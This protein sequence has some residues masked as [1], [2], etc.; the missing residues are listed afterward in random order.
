MMNW[1]FVKSFLQYFFPMVFLVLIISTILF[2]LRKNSELHI[3]KSREI[4]TIQ[5]I[6]KSFENE[7][8]SIISDLMVLVE[9]EQ[10]KHFLNSYDKKHLSLIIKEFLTVCKWKMAY[11]QLR[12]INLHGQEIVRINMINGKCI[13]VGEPNLQNKNERY[14]FKETIKQKS[15]EV[16]ISSF[17]L[18]VENGKIE[19]PLKPVVRFS[20]PV[21]D[22]HDKKKGIIV[23]NYL[24][25]KILNRIEEISKGSV[26]EISVINKEGYWLLSPN[27]DDEWGFMFADGI[28]KKYKYRFPD[29]WNILSNNSSEQFQN[30]NGI[31]TYQHITHVNKNKINV[32]IP[33]DKNQWK[34]ISRITPETIQ[35]STYSIF[36]D[37]IFFNVYIFLLILIVSF[38][39]ARAKYRKKLIEDSLKEKERLQGVVEMAGAI[40]HEINQP[41]Q[42]ISTYIDLLI[43]PE[44]KNKNMEKSLEKILDQI[45]R[46]GKISRKLS[47][48]TKYKTRDYLKG[49]K[50]IDIDKSS[51][52][53]T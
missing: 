1:S 43:H 29:S 12:L 25:N 37:F 32:K 5:L 33:N 23:I 7:F 30:A 53:E 20:T 39:L 16:Y 17:D 38:L 18:N 2:E 3:I 35:K 46:I 19:Y 26:G 8:E 27:P 21:F 40:S 42:I 44:N 51:E 24:G 9:S 34:I 48:I 22:N 36:T 15:G 14:Y 6:N 45:G 13:V 31:F 49:V 10:L 11:D 28:N 41:L 50:I 52:T 4:D 47:K